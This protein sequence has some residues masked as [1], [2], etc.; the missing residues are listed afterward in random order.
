MEN[1]RRSLTSSES[2]PEEDED[3][4]PPL[5]RWGGGLGEEDGAPI[6]DDDEDDIVTVH[7]TEDG[8]RLHGLENAGRFDRSGGSFERGRGEKG[9]TSTAPLPTPLN[10][11]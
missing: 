1:F 3:A 8:S 4:G 5:R 10:I 7:I 2:E 9:L 6:A 11:T